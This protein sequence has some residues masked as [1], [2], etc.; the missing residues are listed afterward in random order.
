MSHFPEKVQTNHIYYEGFEVNNKKHCINLVVENKAV[1]I[2]F[3]EFAA[4]FAKKKKE[5]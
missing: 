3:R 1:D 5:S 2:F 4:S